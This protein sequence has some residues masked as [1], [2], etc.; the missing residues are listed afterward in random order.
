MATNNDIMSLAFSVGDFKLYCESS[1]SFLARTSYTKASGLFQLTI[2]LG[3][4][5]VD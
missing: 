5:A 3:F 4:I 2:I 1:F